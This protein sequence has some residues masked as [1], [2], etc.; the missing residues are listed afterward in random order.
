LSPALAGTHFDSEEMA[1]KMNRILVV[2]MAGLGVAGWS[3]SASADA[4][5]GKA[6][7]EAACAECHEAGDFEGEDAKALADS[8]KKIA[9]GEMKHKSKITLSEAEIAS[10]AAYMAS[11]GK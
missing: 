8:L 3:M 2:A 1:M 10:V 4:A 6:K 5:A 9:S 7:F 11:G